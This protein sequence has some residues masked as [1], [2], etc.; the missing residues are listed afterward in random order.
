MKQINWKT[1]ITSL[2][3]SLGT[4][5]LSALITSDSM[6]IYKELYKPPL[7]PPGWLFPIV[8]T[9]LYLLM[10]IAAYMVYES[11][12]DYEVK[13]SALTSYALQLIVNAGWS[14]IFFNLG[15]YLLAFAWLVLLWILILITIRKFYDVH[16]QAGILMLPYLLWVTFAGYLN[17]AIAVYYY[18]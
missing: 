14:V 15:A 12:A 4:G 11:D 1:L 10:G 9:I 17:L 8:W 16:K 13:K 5:A 18:H 6:Q 2:V 3:I 7:A